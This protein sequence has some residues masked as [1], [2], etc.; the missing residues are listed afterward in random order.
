MKD[1]SA[2]EF[3]NKDIKKSACLDAMKC[4][5]LLQNKA[6]QELILWL[7]TIETEEDIGHGMVSL[8]HHL[9]HATKNCATLNNTDQIFLK[10]YKQASILG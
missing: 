4:Q 9:H 5:I 8:F 7:E 10:F 3:L 6:L 2:P 1:N